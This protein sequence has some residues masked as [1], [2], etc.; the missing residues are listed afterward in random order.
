MLLQ[1][2]DVI[3]EFGYGSYEFIF[4]DVPLHLTKYVS[5]NKKAMKIE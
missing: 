1:S 2:C 4:R 5:W 3:S